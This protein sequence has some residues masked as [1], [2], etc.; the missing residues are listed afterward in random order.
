MT[1]LFKPLSI[2][3]G[4]AAGLIAKKLFEKSWGLV[5]DVEPPDS[6]HRDVDLRM[7]VV[8]LLLEGAIFTVVRGLI[9]Q[10]ARRSF[11][12]YTGVWPGEERPEVE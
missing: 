3:A 6:G 8:A 1:I 10:L 4:L 5:N 12:R 2:L 11:A 9:D 7:L